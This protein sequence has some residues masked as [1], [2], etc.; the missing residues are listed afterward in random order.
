MVGTSGLQGPCK[1]EEST[2]YVNS[3]LGTSLRVCLNSLALKIA[4]QFL[5]GDRLD[6]HDN[7]WLDS[8]LKY[9]SC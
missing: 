7:R 9:M 4:S 6:P 1:L 3:Q 8:E 5:V 2:N